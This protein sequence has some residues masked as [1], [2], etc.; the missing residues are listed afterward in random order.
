MK[1]KYKYILLISCMC[2]GACKKNVLDIVPTDRIS[3]TAIWTD[4]SLAQLFINAQYNFLQDGFSNDIQYF[5]D[6]CFNN[7]DLGGY[8]TP[9]GKAA[10][11]PD[12]V[13]TLSAYFNY[14]NTGYAAIANFNTFFSKIDGVPAD[15]AVKTKMIAEVK[16]LRAFVYAKLIWNYGGVPIIDKS[17]ELNGTLTGV[18]RNTYDECVTYIL[19]DLNDAIAGLPDQQTGSN[20]GRACADAA[21]ALKA[22]V[23][24]YYAS[25]LNNPAKIAQRWQDVSATALEL[26]NN[27]RYSLA[28]DYHGL[29]TGAANSE[30][31]F[32]KFFST[33]NSHNVGFFSAP[34]GSGGADQRAPTQNLVDAYEM[35]NGVIP[36]I[37]GAVNPDPANTY[38]PANPYVNRDPRFYASVLYNG[39]QFKGRTFQ[40]YQGGADFGGQDSP[41]AGYGMYK[42]IDQGLPVSLSTPYTY[43]WIYFRLSEIYLIYAEAQY[44]LGNEANARLYIN[45]VRDRVNMPAITE[46]GTALFDRL[47]HERQVEFAFEAQRYYD[48][49]RWKIAPQTDAAP[50]QG[51]I[52]ANNGGNFT[53]NRVNIFTRAWDDKLY[54]LP[55]ATKEIRSSG[56]SLVQTPGY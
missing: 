56:G 46:T 20:L 30:I 5:G 36:V 4:A 12:N 42:F 43:P 48:T 15:A 16:F 14:Y 37:N 8:Q 24:L 28:P 35:T 9:I 47:V 23:L 27:N 26:I 3:E 21:K 11:T 52:I 7:A 19:K 49:R 18:K 1:F 54:Y 34:L 55:I 45:K 29:F 22:R 50:I 40:P 13:N 2:L 33:A 39:A 44:N 53:Y 38:N 41:P 32:G 31:I 10:L 17:F 51:F 6:E 25:P